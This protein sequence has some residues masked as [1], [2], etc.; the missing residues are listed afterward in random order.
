MYK[1]IQLKRFIFDF[2]FSETFPTKIL[3]SNFKVQG[4]LPAQMSEEDVR[5]GHGYQKEIFDGKWDW[6]IQ[7]SGIITLPTHNMLVT[8]VDPIWDGSV[9]YGGGN[10]ASC[11]KETCPH[12]QDPRCDF[13]CPDAGEYVSDRDMDCQNDKQEEITGNRHYN[14]ACDAIESM[15]LAHAIAGVNIDTPAYIEGIES[16]ID[17]VANSI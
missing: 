3:C 17:G 15:V 14:Y 16:A 12:C 5:E 2:I 4:L 11:L 7:K 9:R 1:R 8:L 13:D 6:L 10:I